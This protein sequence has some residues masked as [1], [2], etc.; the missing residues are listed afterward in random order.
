[1]LTVLLAPAGP[2]RAARVW[3][4]GDG[5]GLPDTQQFQTTV[6]TLVTADVWIDSESFHWTYFVIF[7]QRTS[8][9]VFAG[10]QYSISGGEN[11]PIDTFTNARA[12]G[13]GGSLYDNH[14]L[15]LIGSL[16]AWANRS[17]VFCFSPITD[18]DNVFGTFCTIGAAT[19]Y[20]LFGTS[21]NTCYQ[22]TGS[23]G[24]E[25]LTWGHLKALYR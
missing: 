1:M 14:G 25:T 5:D 10:A 3:M 24:A 8:N 13:F 21:D 7:V 12:T 6:G 15:D 17:G 20:A 2:V 16:T 22:A 19:D 23:T 4:D 9:F 18:P 11:F